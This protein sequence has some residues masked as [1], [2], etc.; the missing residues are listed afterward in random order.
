MC[1]AHAVASKRTRTFE[2][3]S[4]ALNPDRAVVGSPRDALCGLEI[5]WGASETTLGGL[6]IAFRGPKDG[7]VL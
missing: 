7:I 6:V 4:K 5:V 1:P 3:V 2:G